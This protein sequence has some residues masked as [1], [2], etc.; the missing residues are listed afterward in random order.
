MKADILRIVLI[1]ATLLLSVTNSQIYDA[2]RL[3][4]TW[5]LNQDCSSCNEV[6]GWVYLNDTWQT[7]T[8]ALQNTAIPSYNSIAYCHESLGAE[9]FFLMDFD[10]N[11]DVYQ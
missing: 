10:Y 2:K 3:L 9:Y 4:Q 7:E 11:L 5:N 6:N 8:T 1:I